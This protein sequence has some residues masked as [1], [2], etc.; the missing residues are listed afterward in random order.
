MTLGVMFSTAN[1]K[2]ENYFGQNII[3][4]SGAMESIDGSTDSFLL[5]G[6]VFKMCCKCFP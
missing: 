4:Q 5:Y 2:Q 3:L 6:T 1:W